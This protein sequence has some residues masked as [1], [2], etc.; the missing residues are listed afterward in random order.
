M[1]LVGLVTLF[2]ESG[3]LNRIAILFEGVSSVGVLHDQSG[4]RKYLNAAERKR[5]RQAIG[6][7]EHPIEQLF[8]LTLFFTGCRISEAL[9]LTRE[10]VD[11]SEGTLIFRTLKQRKTLRYRSIPIPTILLRTIEHLGLE[12]TDRLFPFGRTKGWAIIKRCMATADLTG[13]K[14][15]P[16]GLRHAY[17]IACISVNVPLPKLQKWMGHTKL[18]TTAI[19]LDYVGDEDRQFA[20]RLWALSPGH[21]HLKC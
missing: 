20:Q 13:T 14:A 19:Y 10:N 7:F 17:A 1:V 9:A 3:R 16:K 18:K 15:T 11:S 5:F 12:R 2:R 21:L 6:S 8:C 4:Q